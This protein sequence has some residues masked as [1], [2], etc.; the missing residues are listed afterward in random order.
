M[1]VSSCL[2]T[3]PGAVGGQPDLPVATPATRSKLQIQAS[4]YLPDYHCLPR[5]Q[6]HTPPLQASPLPL[7]LANLQ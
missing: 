3:P 7:G 6:P 1:A 5:C 2:P 4:W